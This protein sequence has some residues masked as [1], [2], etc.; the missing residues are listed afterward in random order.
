MPRLLRP[1]FHSAF[2]LI[3]SL[4]LLAVCSG[5]QAPPETTTQLT[6]ARIFDSADF[7]TED[8]WARPTG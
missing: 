6:V 5:A 7:H 2:I 4:R 1:I 3:T 8:R